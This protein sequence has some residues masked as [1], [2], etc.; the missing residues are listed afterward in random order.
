MPR[1]RP[2]HRLSRPLTALAT[3][4]LITLTAGACTP[5]QEPESPAPASST[6]AAP[7][8]SVA[9]SEGVTPSPSVASPSVA[10][11]GSASSSGSESSSG[12][13]SRPGTSSSGV[14]SPSAASGSLDG[15]VLPAFS[16]MLGERGGYLDSAGTAQSR[17]QLAASPA[18]AT[19]EPASC[20]PA[21]TSAV[22][23][24]Y[25]VTEEAVVGASEQ[26]DIV[27]SAA[28]MSDADTAEDVLEEMA[29]LLERCDEYTLV[30]ADGGR[31]DLTYAVE[32]TELDGRTALDITLEV[33]TAQGPVSTTTTRYVAAEDTVVESTVQVPAS[34]PESSRTEALELRDEAI[35]R[36]LE[37]LP[38]DARA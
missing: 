27:L 16:E 28:R 7:S 23:I 33:A 38:S 3:A 35:A 30:Q 2:V 37:S 4:A 34:S 25:P 11:P 13:A 21:A 8:P 17:A 26:G 1:T 6:S 18:R 15:T 5:A 24:M 20:L 32:R 19:V 9:L 22:D 29:R 36:I 14:A 10:S 12:A 31:Q